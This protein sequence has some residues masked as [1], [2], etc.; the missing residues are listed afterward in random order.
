MPD[1][2]F[3]AANSSRTVKTGRRAVFDTSRFELAQIDLA[4]L[5][6]NDIASRNAY[7]FEYVIVQRCQA[8]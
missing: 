8:A 2:V 5:Q 7:V 6:G 4:H 1:R 3:N